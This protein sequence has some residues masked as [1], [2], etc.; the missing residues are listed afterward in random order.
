MVLRCTRKS[1]CRSQ[2]ARPMIPG[3]PHVRRDHKDLGVRLLFSLLG[4]FAGATS[5]WAIWGLLTPGDYGPSGGTTLGLITTL[6]A[7]ALARGV[8][9]VV[10]SRALRSGL[11]VAALM[12]VVFW[13]AVPDG[14][15]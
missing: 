15:W 5:S 13:V 11:A 6:A 1:Y 8:G 10:R 2:L 9:F 4:A 14:W 12:S 7:A 3:I